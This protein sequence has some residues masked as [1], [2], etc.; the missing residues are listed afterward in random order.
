MKNTT[1]M[2]TLVAI[3]N[4]PV[5]TN[6]NK[7]K[8]VKSKTSINTKT[9][10]KTNLTVLNR[11]DKTDLNIWN[12]DNV[13]CQRLEDNSLVFT[14]TALLFHIPPAVDRISFM[15]RILVNLT[16]QV[17]LF[18]DNEKNWNLRSVKKTTLG[19]SNGIIFES[20]KTNV[21]NKNN[22][23]NIVILDNVERFNS[24]QMIEILTLIK[25]FKPNYFYGLTTLPTLSWVGVEPFT[26]SVN[27]I[28]VESETISMQERLSEPIESTI[29]LYP[30]QIEVIKAITSQTVL[31][32]LPTG[33]GKTIIALYLTQFFDSILIVVPLIT[34]H[35]Q[36]LDAINKYK[37]KNIRLE[38][39]QTFRNK[40]KKGL[41]TKELTFELVI[42]DEIHLQEVALFNIIIN[43]IYYTVFV[44][45][46][47]TPKE[48]S[49]EW[50]NHYFK[51]IISR[52]ITKAFY[53]HPVYTNFKPTEV[54]RK[55]MLAIK[56][57]IIFKGVPSFKGYGR[58]VNSLDYNKM[59][60]SLNNNVQ[61]TNAIIDFVKTI[62]RL[63]I[64]ILVKRIDTITNLEAGLTDYTVD[65]I[66]GT[67]NVF[68]RTDQIVIGTYQKIGVG[69]DTNHFQTL[70]ILDNI[71]NVSQAEGRLRNEGFDIFDFIDNH[72]IFVNHWD[73][74]K[75]WYLGRGGKIQKEVYLEVKLSHKPKMKA[76]YNF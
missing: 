3:N 54:R 50:Y 69:V 22:E 28:S 63:P 40:L 44:A 31:L 26:K 11:D 64:L 57:K 18:T 75:K 76:M 37:L 30:N 12:L 74:R 39:L 15:N 55:V 47:A 27:I 67:K 73:K 61:R 21:N 62:K 58:K 19:D 48:D 66:Y 6:T 36:W 72:P 35:Q 2:E 46:T 23:I 34:I 5:K 17:L 43:S 42:F 41:T 56:Q 20:Q 9:V 25:K 45:M 4:K 59:V 10:K 29:K 53:V 16:G 14:E 60:S 68:S 70:I 52:K 1:V 49:G 65:T 71:D 38:K 33:Y 32:H 13:D 8:T 24:M 7:P 51:Q